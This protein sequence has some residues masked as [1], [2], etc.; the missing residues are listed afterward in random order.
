[1]WLHV[2]AVFIIAT[3]IESFPRD[4]HFT[5]SS[6]SHLLMSACHVTLSC[7]LRNHLTLVVSI[8]PQAVWYSTAVCTDL[9]KKETAVIPGEVYTCGLQGYI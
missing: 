7:G 1:M 8:L 4:H 6:T 9:A 5:T 2:L 3:S